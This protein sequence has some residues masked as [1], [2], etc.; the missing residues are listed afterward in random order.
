MDGPCD[1]NHIDATLTH[2]HSPHSSF[3]TVIAAFHFLEAQEKNEFFRV[4]NVVLTRC[5]CAQHPVCIRTHNNDHVRTLKILQSMSDFGGLP[6]HENTQLSLVV[7]LVSAA[8]LAAVA[9]PR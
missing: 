5:R 4:K 7:G 6:K 1:H 2:N 3:Q 9:L 8:L